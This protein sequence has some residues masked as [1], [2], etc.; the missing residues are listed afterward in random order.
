MGEITD[1]E[2]PGTGEV[3]EVTITKEQIE[4][5]LKAFEFGDL[6]IECGACKHVNT[7]LKG[8][9]GI[10]IDMLPNNKQEL[11]LVCANCGNVM[12]M[13]YTESENLDE[14]RKQKEERL[15]EQASKLIEQNEI[16]ENES[17]NIE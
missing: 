11:K 1:N 2:T 5:Q 13:F 16:K 6:H 3:K 10:R 9:E 15:A 4:E 8:I 17:G 12:R 14:L 7:F